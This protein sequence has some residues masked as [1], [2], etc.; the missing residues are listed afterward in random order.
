MSLVI[1]GEFFF[2]GG[3]NTSKPKMFGS[4]GLE[5]T[6]FGTRRIGDEGFEP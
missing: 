5:G 1:L 3:L 6:D 4:L 2:W